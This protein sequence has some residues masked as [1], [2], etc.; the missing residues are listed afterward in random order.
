MIDIGMDLGTCSM[1]SSLL[2]CFLHLTTSSY[3]SHGTMF[4]I[5]STLP[6]DMH[7]QLATVVRLKAQYSSCSSIKLQKYS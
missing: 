3:M 5:L 4:S 1:S 6:C 7:A 2:Q